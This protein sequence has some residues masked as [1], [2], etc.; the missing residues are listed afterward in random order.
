M[1]NILQRIKPDVICFQEV[2][3]AFL[4]EVSKVPW[5]SEEYLCSDPNYDGSSLNGY[6]C[7]ILCKGNLKPHFSFTDFENSN[8]GRHL[9]AMSCEIDGKGKSRNVNVGCVH[10]ESLN[11]A[12]IRK[13]QLLACNALLPP[14]RSILV[15]DFNF[16]SERN[17][18]GSLPLEN[19]CLSDVIPSYQDVWQKLKPGEKGYTFD[20]QINKMLRKFEQAR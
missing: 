20:S 3:T 11:N 18:D 6:G 10:L 17:Y 2:T 16:C 5:I 13:E 1:M 19:D 7:A 8:M 9:L 4:E 12:K 14:G 15:G